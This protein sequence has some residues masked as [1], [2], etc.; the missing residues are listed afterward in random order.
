MSLKRSDSWFGKI[1][2]G[3]KK[4]AQT[5]GG[6]IKNMVLDVDDQG[7]KTLTEEEIE[8]IESILIQ[9]DVGVKVAADICSSLK[10][11][12]FSNKTEILQTISSEIA[13]IL[14][15]YSKPFEIKKNKNL[16]IILLSGVNGSGKTTTIAK[17]AQK[18]LSKGLKVEFAACDTFRA[19]A[20]EQLEFWAQKLDIKIYKS[21]EEN[22]KQEPASLAFQAVQEAKKNNTDVLFI[23][24][25]GR[26]QNNTQL[27]Q[28]LAKIERT[29]KKIDSSAPH[30]SII[31]LDGTTGQNSYSQVELF[32][33]FIPIT[34]MI[35]T[36]L[37][38]TAKAGFVIGLCQE[39][40]I[41]VTAIGVGEGIDDLDDLEP[42][43]FAD[44][45]VGI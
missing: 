28:E 16:N 24:T 9:G 13:G 38:G 6:G 29:V 31:V 1:R 7:L 26:L 40:K 5:L 11:K 44:S 30:Q 12:S 10:K 15:K 3:L 32:N 27:M 4:T 25:A 42:V 39:T 45:L 37:D 8:E 21:K 41:P 35:V 43:I 36:K 33:K 17:L 18:C 34:S 14:S 2:A 20:E 23:D 22:K 19:A